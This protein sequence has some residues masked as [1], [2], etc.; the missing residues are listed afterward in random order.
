MPSMKRSSLIL[1]M[2]LSTG[3]L[4]A[5]IGLPG[6]GDILL[7]ITSDQPAYARSEKHHSAAKG[8]TPLAVPPE[9]RKEIEVPMPEK[10]A[11]QAAKDGTGITAKEKKAIAGKAVTLDSRAYDQTAARV[12]SAVVDAMT[13]L[14]MP[15][16]SVDSPS[17]TITT[18]WIRPNANSPNSYAGV[19]MNMLGGGGTHTRYRFV[20]RVFR[21]GDHGSQLQIRTLGQQFINRHWVNKPVRRKVA[22]ELFSAVE[23]RIVARA[24]GGGSGASPPTGHM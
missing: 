14:N 20:I 7:P 11:T 24:P 16:A 13:S 21:T 5:C 9:L 22:N 4:N 17:G 12:F 1:V 19:V 6:L 2:L 3:A 15:V 18:D 23:E 8:R 10:V